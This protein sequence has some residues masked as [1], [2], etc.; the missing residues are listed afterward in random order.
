ML[1]QLKVKRVISAPLP[2]RCSNN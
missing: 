2:A 1:I